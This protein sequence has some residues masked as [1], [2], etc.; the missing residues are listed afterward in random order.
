MTEPIKPTVRK[1]TPNLIMKFAIW[2][3]LVFTITVFLFLGIIIAFHPEIIGLLFY[4]T[5]YGIF[6]HSLQ[7][8]G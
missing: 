1:S 2:F 7:C 5:C 4:I 6:Q 8:I 3:S